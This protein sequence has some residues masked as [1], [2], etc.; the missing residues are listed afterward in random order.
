MN[1]NQV[2]ALNIISTIIREL[3]SFL[4]NNYNQFFQWR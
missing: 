4:N 1:N 2:M 3:D